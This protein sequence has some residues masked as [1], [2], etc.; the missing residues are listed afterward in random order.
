MKVADEV[1]VAAALLQSE[2]PER[3]DFAGR[4]I[5]E[6]A[7]RE[8]WALRPGFHQHVSSHCVANKPADPANHR[9]LFEDSRGRR[10]LYRTGDPCHQDRE[11]GKVRPEKQD[12]LQQ[13]QNLIDWYD[14]VYSKQPSRQSPTPS[15]INSRAVLAREGKFGK[16]SSL[17]AQEGTSAPG[18]AFVSSAGALVIPEELRKKFGIGEG[19][20]LSIY[21]EGEHL[22]LQPVTKEYVRSLVGCCKGGPSMV[23]AREREHR[24]EK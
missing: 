1:W 20:R 4:E 16:P 13:Y 3:D 6:R 14:A 11:Q 7:R 10:R 8:G 21:K 22:V 24:T 18:T 12:I 5:K 19:T 17:N 2:N 9:M 23:E 15:N